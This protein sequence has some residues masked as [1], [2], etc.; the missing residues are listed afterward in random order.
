MITYLDLF[1]LA[2]GEKI[3]SIH[4]KILDL[5]LKPTIG[6]HD[7]VYDWKGIVS[8]DEEIEFIENIQTELKG[9]GAILRFSTIR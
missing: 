5:G 1:L 3:S 6:G 4:K 2:D 7:Y 9:T 8:I